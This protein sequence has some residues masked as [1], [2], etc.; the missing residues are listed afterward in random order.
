[1]MPSTPGG[2]LPITPTVNSSPAMNVSTKS[3]CRSARDAPTLGDIEDEI[4]RIGEQPLKKWPAIAQLDDGVTERF[5]R[6]P[7]GPHRGRAVELF[8]P[9]I[10]PAGVGVIRFERESEADFHELVFRL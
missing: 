7:D 3:G 9:V 5:Q 1:M 8:L 10:G 2:S 4:R 6:R